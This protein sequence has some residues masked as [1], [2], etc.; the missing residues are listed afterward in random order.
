MTDIIKKMIDTYEEKGDFTY[1]ARQVC[2]LPDT[3]RHCGSSP[4]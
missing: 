2:G 1:R 4:V 3:R